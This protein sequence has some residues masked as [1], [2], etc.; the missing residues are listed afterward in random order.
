MFI[1]KEN[2]EKSNNAKM[3]ELLRRIKPEMHGAVVEEMARRGVRYGLSYGVAIP[4]IRQAAREYAPDHALAEYLFRQDVRELKLAAVYVDDPA[5]VAREQIERWTSAMPPAEVMEHAAM[6][7]FYASP[8]APAVIGEWLAADDPLRLKG[9]LYMAGRRT[10]AGLADA[11]ESARHL[12]LAVK[13]LPS[14]TDIPE[15]A[16]VYFFTK[17][18]VVSADLSDSVRRVLKTWQT[19]ENPAIRELASEVAAFLE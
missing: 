13:S 8:D 15:Q 7:L 2:V 18:A 19:H 10:L 17:T 6:N 16:A 12:N 5:L 14:Q 11:E 9:A 4:V 3:V 1:S